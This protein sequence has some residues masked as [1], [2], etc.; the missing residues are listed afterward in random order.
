[1]YPAPTPALVIVSH[2]N[3]WEPDRLIALLDQ[4]D[5]TP[6]GYPYRRRVVVNQAVDRPLVLPERHRDVAVSYRENTGY[7][8]GAWN[9]GWKQEPP[10]EF[11]LFVQEECQILKDNWLGAFVTPLQDPKVGLVGE[12][13]K[14]RGF[15]WPRVEYYYRGST[16]DSHACPDSPVPLDR[17]I[18][19]VLAA[20]QIPPGRRAAHLQ[21]LILATR[22][23]CLLATDGFLIRNA[24]GDAVGAEV[25]TSKRLEALGY[26]VVQVGARPFE[27]ISHPQWYAAATDTKRRLF[28][29]VEPFLPIRLADG[30]H[31]F[32][33]RRRGETTH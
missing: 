21:S 2:Y 4:M 9:F 25:A 19:A 10:A 7:N 13:L 23:E 11:Y 17:A 14:W 18:H 22:R 3:A 8:I 1:M 30:I 5:A 27:Y 28:R 29:T 15:T 32:M 26:R 24:Y 20:E 6:A 12:S 16:Y 33:M 31:H